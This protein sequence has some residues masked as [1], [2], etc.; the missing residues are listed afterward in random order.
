MKI[1]VGGC[2][3]KSPIFMCETEFPLKVDGTS[4]LCKAVFISVNWLVDLLVV[5]AHSFGVFR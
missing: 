3:P 4:P 5:K 1:R 2:C